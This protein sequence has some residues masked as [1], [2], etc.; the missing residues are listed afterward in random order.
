MALAWAG[1]TVFPPPHRRRRWMVTVG[2]P[3]KRDTPVT[4]NVQATDLQVS[5]GA[6]RAPGG[7]ESCRWRCRQHTSSEP[8]QD[9]RRPHTAAPAGRLAGPQIPHK[10]SRVHSF[11][12]FLLKLVPVSEYTGN[13]TDVVADP[14]SAQPSG[15]Q[16]HVE[17]ANLPVPTPGRGTDVRHPPSPAGSQRFLLCCFR[18]RL[19]FRPLALGLPGAA[20]HKSSMPPSH[21]PGPLSPLRGFC[22]GLLSSPSTLE[23][24]TQAEWGVRGGS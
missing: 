21:G 5:E 24:S 17:P 12:M 3:E 20:A 15:S 6:H 16:P 8:G 23:S 19:S 11:Q 22:G 4:R 2:A 7:A 14:V 13:K 1:H 9:G 18:V 10:H